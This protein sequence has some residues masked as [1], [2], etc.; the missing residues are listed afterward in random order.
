MRTK[1]LPHFCGVSLLDAC[2]LFP[3]FLLVRGETCHHCA[4][5]NLA[6]EEKELPNLRQ[7]ERQVQWIEGNLT[8]KAQQ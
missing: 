5:Q 8:E 7:E 6:L 3:P 4:W 1:T 2:S